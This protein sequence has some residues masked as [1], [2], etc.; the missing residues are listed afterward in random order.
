MLKPKKILLLWLFISVI[1]FFSCKDD[2]PLKPKEPDIEMPEEPDIEGS[3]AIYILNDKS[4]KIDEMINNGFD[5]NNYVGQDISSLVN[6]FNSEVD[7]WLSSKD[8]EFY[9]YSTHLIYLKRDKSFLFYEDYD[10][11]HAEF[12]TF[13]ERGLSPF[14]VTTDRKVC[15]MGYFYTA[16]VEFDDIEPLFDMPMI[17]AN[18]GAYAN[19]IVLIP[20]AINASNR[21][22]DTLSIDI[23]NNND[24]VIALKKD[25]IFRGGLK[26]K[27]NDFNL[28]LGGGV[29]YNI[30]ECTYT[31]TNNDNEELY[32]Y[33][34]DDLL[35]ASFQAN[36]IRIFYTAYHNMFL[37]EIGDKSHFTLVKPGE[38]IKHKRSIKRTM[39]FFPNVHYDCCFRSSVPAIIS[40]KERYI[41]GKRIWMGHVN[42]NILSLLYTGNSVTVNK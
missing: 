8:I 40:K 27:L 2:V 4:I 37:E 3:F 42:S 6:D 16:W 25:N 36:M 39:P 15:Y 10:K 14:I 22:F 41:D 5:I 18:D 35:V 11:G 38:S 24:L 32:F 29:G 12:F 1:A 31:V 26:I 13:E 23:R 9:D 30:V 21:E 17:Q 33:T 19:D 20:T 28:I 7:I 34:W